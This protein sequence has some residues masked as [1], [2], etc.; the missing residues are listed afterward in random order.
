MQKL[1]LVSFSYAHVPLILQLNYFV[2][3]YY[4]T[5]AVFSVI[6][7]IIMAASVI[8]AIYSLH[9]HH[10]YTYKRLCACLQGFAGQL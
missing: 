10:R 5:Q 9:V 8:C 4:R 1:K 2:T 7:I 3:D 6:S